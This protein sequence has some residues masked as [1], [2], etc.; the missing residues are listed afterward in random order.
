MPNK[1]AGQDIVCFGECMIELSRAA[2]SDQW[3]LGFAGDTA[4]V[5]VYCARLGANTHY[6]SAVGTDLFSADMWSFLAGE[7]VACDMLLAHPDRRVG[8]YA[9]H[10]DH[11]GERSFTYWRDNSAVRD[12]FA[13]R[14]IAE[15]LSRTHSARI[16]Y[17]SGITLSLFDDAGR[18]QII[19]L[20]QAVRAAG[21]DVAFDGNYRPA[22]WPDSAAA[23]AAFAAIAPY[24][25]IILPTFADEADLFGDV[26]PEDSVSR[27]LDSGARIVAVK[28]GDQGALVAEAG[29]G[30][31]MVACP[32]PRT[33]VDTTGAGDSFNAAFLTVL[34]AGSDPTAAALAGHRLA[35]EVV[36]HPGAIIGRAAM[37][38][39]R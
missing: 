32:Q 6:L 3:R 37:M 14:G 29:K 38:P 28:L 9:I 17:L 4:N 5:A 16:L 8:L 31:Q 10:T 12:I 1:Q 39:V 34:L 26:R 33:P 11:L 21:G 13:L 18:A 19:A 15:A 35:G 27:W 22:G 2:A 20:A 25:S 24:C 30:V 7:G 23:R 36:M